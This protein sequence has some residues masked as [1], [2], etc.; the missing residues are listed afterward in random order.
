MKDDMNYGKGEEFDIDKASVQLGING[1]DDD[2]PVIDLDI[3]VMADEPTAEDLEMEEAEAEDKI[4]P[5][6]TK[7]ITASLKTSRGNP[8][9]NK[10]I[11]F[12]VNGKTYE[13]DLSFFFI[14]NSSRIAGFNDVYY[15]GRQ[16]KRKIG[17]S[18]GKYRK[19]AVSLNK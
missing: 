2:S 14:T 16:F 11:S 4:V 9:A 17:V 12:T 19:G 18:P 13:D 5:V 7:T 3:D 8:L 6:K 10:Q 1:M 15:F